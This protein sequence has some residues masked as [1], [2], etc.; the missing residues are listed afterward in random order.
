MRALSAEFK[1]PE[2]EWPTTVPA[3]QSI[4]NN[5]PSRRL[6]NR[7]PITVHTGMKPGN[8]LALALS[9]INYVDAATTD[10]ARVMQ[11]LKIDEMQ[12]SLDDMHKAVSIT[13]NASRKKAVSRH[14]A[15]TGVHPCNPSAGDY[16]VVARTRG[17]RTKMS[18]NWVGPRRI[19]QVLSDFTFKVEH[20]ITKQTEDIHVSRIKPYADDLVGQPAQMAEIADFSDRVWYCVDQIRDIRE[21]EGEFQVLV[22]WKGLSTSGDSWEPLHIMFEDV[23]SKIR[24]YFQRRRQSDTMKRAKLSINL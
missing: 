6:G 23:P 8:P 4:I 3:I 10:E 16:V 18:A 12:K 9:A 21:I 11:S 20:L 15:R 1:I 19:V 24:S 13:L 5:T 7:A 14:N 2:V 17:P 22:S